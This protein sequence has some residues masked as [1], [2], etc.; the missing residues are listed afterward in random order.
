MVVAG[1]Q[2][3][4]EKLYPP[5]PPPGCVSK[6]GG[7]GRGHGGTERDQL[8]TRSLARWFPSRSYG[9]VLR[10]GQALTPAA[11]RAVQTIRPGLKL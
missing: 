7:G 2:T 11:H 3:G 8:Y 6:M 5:P 1:S 4:V 9:V 10:K